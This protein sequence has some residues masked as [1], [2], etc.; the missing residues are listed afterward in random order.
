MTTDLVRHYADGAE[1]TRLARTP[2][3]RLEFLRTQEILRRFLTAPATVLDVGGGTGVHAEWLARDGHAVHLVDVVPAHVDAAAVLPGVTALLGDARRL[4]VADGSVDAVLVLGPL[5]HL[6][7]PADRA[8]ALAEARR[9]LRPGGVLAAAGI[10]RYLSVVEAGANGALDADLV[11]S[12]EAVVA[13]GRYDGHV[14]FTAAHWHTA[15]ELRAEVRAAGL[16][17]VEVYGVEGP[18]WAALDAAGAD[19]FPRLVP[20][21]LRCARLVERDPLLVNASAHF[22]ALGRAPSA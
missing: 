15:D 6:T 14:G 18:G 10:S 13:T 1:S 5:Y 4:P 3:G 20:A 2:H 17:D 19:E 22:L 8:R 7:D 16:A 9:V 21:A 12:V 11:P